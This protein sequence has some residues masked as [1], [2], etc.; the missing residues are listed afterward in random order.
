MKVAAHNDKGNLPRFGD[1]MGDFHED[2]EGGITGI[3]L[4]EG[5][6]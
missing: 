1:T 2:A 5:R 3:N 4:S 6:Q